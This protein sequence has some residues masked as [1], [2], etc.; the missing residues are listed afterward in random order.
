[1]A[2]GNEIPQVSEEDVK[3]KDNLDIA[4]D[5]LSKLPEDFRGDVS[6]FLKDITT[7]ILAYSTRLSDGRVL[8]RVKDEDREHYREV[9]KEILDSDILNPHVSPRKEI[10]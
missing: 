1:M 9:F 4:R 7:S 10:K 6:G 8:Y 5:A 2:E 3:P